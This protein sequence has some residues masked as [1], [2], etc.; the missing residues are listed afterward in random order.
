MVVEGGEGRGGG[1][2]ARGCG[3]GCEGV[4]GVDVRDG[5]ELGAGVGTVDGEG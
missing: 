2:G 5:F 4:Q 3:C 1:G